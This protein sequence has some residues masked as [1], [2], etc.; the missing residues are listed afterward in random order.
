[1]L[2]YCF[3]IILLKN[4]IIEKSQNDRL[5]EKNMLRVKYLIVALFLT[6]FLTSCASTYRQVP[7]KSP[8]E[9][10]AMALEKVI[11]TP[12]L[13]NAMVGV[14]VQSL[15]TGEILYQK[16]AD[17]VFMP[18]S[19]EKIPT[20]T[21]ALL[22]FGPDFRYQTRVVT[23]GKI[24]G[25]KLAGD[26]IVIGSGDPTIGYRFCERRDSCLAFASW[27]DSLKS[28]GIESIT[29]NIVGID[30]V[31]DDEFIGYGWTVDNLPYSYAAEIGGLIF[32]ENYSTLSIMAD[33]SS[34]KIDIALFPDINYLNIIPQIKL[35]EETKINIS[36]VYTTNQV[37]LKGTIE[38]GKKYSRNIS[39]HNPTLYFLTALKAEL[40]K[41]GISVSGRVIDA[42]EKPEL[43]T[44]SL[45]T[46]LFVHYSDS[47]KNILKILLKE[48]QN[49]YAES[50]VK[51]LGHHF[52][53]N[54]SFDEGRKVVQNSLRR[55]GLQEENYQY[56]DGS[57]LCR[58]NYISPAY[59]VKIFR[60][61]YFHPYGEIFRQC[62]PIA[63]VDGTIGYRMHGTIAQGKI[64]AKTGTISNV[65]CLSGYA[66]TKDG[67]PLVFS[68]M[69]NNFLCSV[70]VVLDVQDQIC[71]L[72]S[73]FHRVN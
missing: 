12:E 67:E 45:F 29:G 34:P 46:P 53:E 3:F 23:N 47:L 32:N 9:Q 31:F 21:A 22:N 19:N 13:S 5:G 42:D 44:D 59:L 8:E 11:N 33:S 2:L 69:F 51:L 20:S 25:S 64:F 66:F 65:R 6:I 49:L 54:G 38:Q 57:G 73:S 58:Y 39:I 18:A 63:G 62:L 16:N 68:T 1:M 10:L 55:F 14:M 61:M 60:R 52:G 72:L 43:K 41:S 26:L 15:E 17:K 71:M 30:D 35:G 24:A 37:L 48:S 40:E 70:Q 4:I 50:L 28:L 36:R 7:L 27:I 56:M